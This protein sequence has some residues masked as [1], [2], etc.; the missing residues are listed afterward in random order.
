MVL[1]KALTLSS[2][3]SGQGASERLHNTE[4]RIASKERSRLG[5]SVKNAMAE[6]KMGAIRKRKIDEDRQL[7]TFWR[8]PV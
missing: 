8:W 1:I 6:I 4:K 3:Q 7:G 2:Q 5:A